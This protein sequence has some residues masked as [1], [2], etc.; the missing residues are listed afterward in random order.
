MVGLSLLGRLNKLVTTAKH[1]DP[2]TTMGGINII[3][4]G[5]YIQYSLVLD[6][7]LYYAEK[8]VI[9]IFVFFM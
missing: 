8:M 6:K 9:Q 1:S 3:L 7:P 2:M 5:D 4:F